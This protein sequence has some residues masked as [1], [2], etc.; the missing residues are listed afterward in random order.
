[1][2]DSLQDPATNFENMNLK[3]QSLTT[4]LLDMN[5]HVG[6]QIWYDNHLDDSYLNNFKGLDIRILCSAVFSKILINNMKLIK[7]NQISPKPFAALCS[8][9]HFNDHQHAKIMGSYFYK[10]L[11]NQMTKMSNPTL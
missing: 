3:I 1:M 9:N 10:W 4:S 6:I 5:Q 8:K 7:P 2:D 11:T